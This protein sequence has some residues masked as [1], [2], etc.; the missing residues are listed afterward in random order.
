MPLDWAELARFYRS[1]RGREVLHAVRKHADPAA[2]TKKDRTSLWLGFGA[3]FVRNEERQ[4]KESV[5]SRQ[6]RQAARLVLAVPRQ[7]GAQPVQGLRGNCTCAID[8]TDFPFSDQEFAHIFVIHALEHSADDIR[9]IQECWRVLEGEG[10][11]TIIVPN[12]T[13]FLARSPHSPFGFGRPYSAY[14][15]QRLLETNG[16]DVTA[17]WTALHAPLFCDGLPARPHAFVD[18][19]GALLWPALAGILIVAARKTVYRGVPMRD[20]PRRIFAPALIANPTQ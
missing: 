8:D 1:A 9:L 13:G 10:I 7:L 15:L 16:F 5:Q 17:D 11:L 2:M 4:A 19:A 14:Q 12:R 6:A 3:P 18:A 20:T